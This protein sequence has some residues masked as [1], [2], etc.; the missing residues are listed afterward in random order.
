M[1]T[2]QDTT[3]GLFSGFTGPSTV[4]VLLQMGS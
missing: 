1:L 2:F 4:L 3:W